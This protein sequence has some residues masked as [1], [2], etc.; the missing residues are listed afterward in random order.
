[1]WIHPGNEPALAEIDHPDPVISVLGDEIVEI[2]EEHPGCLFIIIHEEYPSIIQ[3]GVA[4][5]CEILDGLVTI[6]SQP[7]YPVFQ[8]INPEIGILSGALSLRS[9]SAKSITM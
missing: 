6:V 5:L 4:G 7:D 9:H 3:V 8:I 1:M 2:L